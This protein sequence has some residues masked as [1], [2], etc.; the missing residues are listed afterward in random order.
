MQYTHLPFLYLHGYI[1][2]PRAES[3]IIQRSPDSGS[4]PTS[5]SDQS[6]STGP[7]ASKGLSLFQIA[8]MAF[9]VLTLVLM[10]LGLLV[11]VLQIRRQRRQRAWFRLWS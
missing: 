2:R 3:L 4:S 1:Y 11:Q 6:K 5:T 7:N 8:M 9:G 10:I